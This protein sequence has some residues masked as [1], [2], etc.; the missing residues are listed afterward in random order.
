MERKI[1]SKFIIVTMFLF[2]VLA[3]LPVHS[4]EKDVMYVGSRYTIMFEQ[5]DLKSPR[6]DFIFKNSEVTVVDY[7]QGWCKV[8]CLGKTGWVVNKALLDYKTEDNRTDLSSIEVRKR[9]STFAT[10]A[11]AG[12]G[13]ANENVRDRENVKFKDYDF[14]SIIWIESNFAFDPIYLVE[15][16]KNEYLK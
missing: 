14:S 7:V 9:A 5:P 2:L 12:R 4:V 1:L 11:A 3:S 8:T 10:S 13:L 6:V 15:W 16:S